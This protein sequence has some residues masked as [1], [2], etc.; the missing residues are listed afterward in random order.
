MHF[1]GPWKLTV[2]LHW[3]IG[4]TYLEG[5]KNVSGLKNLITQCNRN[6]ASL[7]KLLFATWTAWKRQKTG[8]RQVFQSFCVKALTASTSSKEV[9]PGGEKRLRL[10]HSFPYEEEGS[11]VTWAHDSVASAE[12]AQSSAAPSYGQRTLRSAMAAAL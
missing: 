7:Y 4:C 1:L 2:Q 9:K 8:D 6:I 5:Q 12:F 11:R 3:V 10:A